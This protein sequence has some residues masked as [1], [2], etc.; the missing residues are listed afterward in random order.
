MSSARVETTKPG[1]YG[2]VLRLVR[3]GEARSR[4][5]LAKLT[6]LAP[7]TVSLRVD[8]LVR[9]GFL[10]EEGIEP[11][12]G[13]RPAKHLSLVGSAGSVAAVD[14]GAH[15]AAVAI[16]D[17]DG[18][19][20]AEETAASED[21]DPATTV[22][23]LWERVVTLHSASGAGPL[24]GLGIGAPA[25]V[26]VP[27]GRIVHPSFRPSWDRV[28]LPSLFAAHTD[29]PVVVDNDANLN[30]LAEIDGD[31]DPAAQHLLAVKL[32]SR[33]GCGVVSEGRLHRGHGGAAGEI[34][35]T[36]VDGTSYIACTCGMAN[37]LESVASGGAL[38]ARLAAAGYDVHTPGEVVELGRTGDP[39]VI[40]ALREAG[41]RIGTV[42][43]SCVNFF[44]PGDVVLGGT[45]SAST[46]LV[47]AIRA[48]LF[49]RCLPI[50]ADR[51]DV[52]AAHEPE[53]AAIR[54]AT[55]LILEAALSPARMDR[56]V[57]R[58][59][60]EAAGDSNRGR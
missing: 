58:A 18:R 22:A 24:F 13:G 15:H 21:P 35:H 41:V 23:Q 6:G 29:L 26:E 40:E 17:L 19:I 38:V 42:L 31:A 8:A 39:V 36:P 57:K 48:E 49:Q 60:V 9:L 27:S 53:K 54:G 2:D 20:L 5:Q 10:I 56:L 37:C 46:P 43:A 50:A 32:G 33:I 44:N 55:L 3:T 34:S 59:L 12:R 45:M 47:A 4:S 28:D 16:A 25:P 7:S 51:L 14:L 30:A 11:S 52:R 1:S